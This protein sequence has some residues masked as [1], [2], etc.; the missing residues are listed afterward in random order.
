MTRFFSTLALVLL[1]VLSA[2]SLT[3]GAQTHGH[4]HG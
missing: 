3:V 2:V 4:S 1:P